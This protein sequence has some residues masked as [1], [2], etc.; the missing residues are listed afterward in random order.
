MKPLTHDDLLM[1][2]VD[3]RA[4]EFPPTMQMLMNADKLLKQINALQE[5]MQVQFT[6][7][8][9]YRPGPYNVKAGGAT[10]S[11][12]L[13]CEAIDIHDPDGVL[14]HKLFSNTQMLDELKLYMEL[15]S[16]TPGWMHLQTRRPGSG[17]LVFKP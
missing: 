15:P 6:V 8:S 5:L 2:G 16:A 3:N 4:S 9:G 7:S 14:K 11:P 12:H 1:I 13:T 10:H 17:S